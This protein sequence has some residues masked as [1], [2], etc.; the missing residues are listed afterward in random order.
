MLSDQWEE[1]SF[2][3]IF[4]GVDLL[5]TVD[6]Q[7]VNMVAKCGPLTVNVY[8]EDFELETDQPKQIQTKK[9]ASPQ[10][11]GAMWKN[12]E[13]VPNHLKGILVITW[14]EWSYFLG[15]LG[16]IGSKDIFETASEVRLTL[17]I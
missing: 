2:K 12:L 8:G 11:Q 10:P 14:G 17:T 4:R 6:R 16:A 3:V 1:Y 13:L 7:Q 9:N 5:V 15:D